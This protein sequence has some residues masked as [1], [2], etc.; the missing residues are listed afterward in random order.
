[1]EQA[2]IR[3]MPR[4]LACSLAVL[5]GALVAAA[6]EGS[7]P[8]AQDEALELSVEADQDAYLPFEPIRV[9]A[10]V[11]N[12]SEHAWSAPVDD[13]CTAARLDVRGI[14]TRSSTPLIRWP[15]HPERRPVQSFCGNAP[16]VTKWH[17]A[18]GWEDTCGV[19]LYG[20]SSP[21]ELQIRLVVT[22]TASERVL[23]SPPLRI[24]V[25]EPTG[26]DRAAVEAI[27]SRATIE[28]DGRRL[29]L[30]IGDVPNHWV[31][32][33]KAGVRAFVERFPDSTLSH[34]ARFWLAIAPEAGPAGPPGAAGALGPVLRE[35]LDPLHPAPPPGARG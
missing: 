21:G 32:Q 19:W 9:R 31:F 34:Y 11:R 17:L 27:R 20:P 6:Q 3:R 33:E 4:A 2:T 28:V 25:L 14:E 18:P 10:R 8:V 1:M 24:Q 29:R 12:R 35:L 23:E 22:F 30:E 15:T 5:A 13:T 7:G 26:D 16:A